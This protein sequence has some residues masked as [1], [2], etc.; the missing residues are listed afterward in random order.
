MK[1]HINYLTG[2][3]FLVYGEPSDRV[4]AVGQQL[5]QYLGC[6]HIDLQF[7][8]H[9]PVNEKLGY[10]KQQSMSGCVLSGDLRG[11]GED[12]CRNVDYGFEVLSRTGYET[13]SFRNWNPGFPSCWLFVEDSPE[14]HGE[15]M[16]EMLSSALD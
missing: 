16:Q 14:R 9:W 6:E 12:L 2:R 10:I 8:K 4:Y 3:M 1:R 13:R 7:M 15:I 5:S 11:W